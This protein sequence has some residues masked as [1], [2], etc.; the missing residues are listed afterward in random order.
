RDA[1]SLGLRRVDRSRAICRNLELH[2]VADRMGSSHPTLV[3][4]PRVTGLDSGGVLVTAAQPRNRDYSGGTTVR[5]RRACV[6]AAG[7]RRV[8]REVPGRNTG[9]LPCCLDTTGRDAGALSR[10]PGA[11]SRRGRVYR[12]RRAGRLAARGGVV[13]GT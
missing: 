13:V 6:V 12:R 5:R 4:G 2:G 10:F 1:G 3:S 7:P 8:D 11:T 9:R